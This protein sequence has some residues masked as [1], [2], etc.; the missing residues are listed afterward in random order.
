[1]NWWPFRRRHRQPE[2]TTEAREARKT[3][4]A[5]R[6]EA[7]HALRRDLARAPEVS[8]VTNSIRQA[9]LRNHF[10]ESMERLIVRGN[11]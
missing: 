10:S 3:A 5:A 11:Q 1:V 6:V 8:Q 7:V 9:H 2:P 4:H